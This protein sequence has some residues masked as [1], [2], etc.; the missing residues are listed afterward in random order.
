MS[1]ESLIALITAI[2]GSGGIGLYLN[3]KSE[4]NRAR[5]DDFEY[6]RSHYREALDK[7]EARLT[8]LEE[9][10]DKAEQKAK[11][12]I[13]EAEEAKDLNEG[14]ERQISELTEQVDGLKLKNQSLVAR[15]EKLES[16]LKG[17]ER[18]NEV[19]WSTVCHIKVGH[20]HC[21]AGFSDLL[22]GCLWSVKCGQWGR[23]F[24]NFSRLPNFLG[25]HF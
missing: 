6:F 15:I 4:Q 24:N 16:E 17:K 2:L 10:R 3:Y 21:G 12:A 20:Y 13:V 1:V 18:T 7:L 14:Y 23:L 19:N 5:R 8:I 25:G 22:G 11:E 9:E